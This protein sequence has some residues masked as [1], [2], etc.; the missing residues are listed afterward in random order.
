MKWP[1]FTLKGTTYD[2]AHLHNQTITLTQ[3]AKGDKPAIVYEIDVE[4]SHH[5]FTS[6]TT[7]RPLDPVL[8]YCD[9]R[10]CRNFDLGRY[11]LSKQL[12]E[13]I[14]TLAQTKCYHSGK[15]NFF[16]V[17]LVDVGGKEK[18]YEIYFA[19]SRSRRGN[20][21]LKLYVQSAYIRTRGNQPTRKPIGL[22]VILA[23]TKN[24]KPIKIQN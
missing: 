6:G 23:N 17:K 21:V 22:F 16:K 5:C 11:E 1:A 7:K 3:P 15:G 18:E 12:P 14:R 13:I 19:A 4:F 10:E 2:L 8:K 9:K 24:N 20:G